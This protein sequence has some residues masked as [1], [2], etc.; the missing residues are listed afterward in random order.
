ME[1]NQ[2]P[3]HEIH[4][5]GERILNLLERI[6]TDQKVDHYELIISDDMSR[7]TDTLTG[8][9]YV[10][11]YNHL[12]PHDNKVTYT[13]ALLRWMIT[14]NIHRL[15]V[16]HPKTGKI[17]V[18]ERDVINF[19][20][21]MSITTYRVKLIPEQIIVRADEK[22]LHYWISNKMF[23][24]SKET[25]NYK[26]VM[27]KINLSDMTHDITSNYDILDTT[28]IKDAI[29]RHQP[30]F[31]DN[32]LLDVILYHDYLKN[33]ILGHMRR[34]MNEISNEICRENLRKMG[35]VDGDF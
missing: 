16:R 1:M 5:A 23:N 11:K 27:T 22:D 28:D 17:D 34:S 8:V 13:D 4:K 24:D 31:N 7:G 32:Y 20:P 10:F 3:L 25:A 15:F 9:A 12:M 6:C 35:D 29:I 26:W 2:T 30:V 18:I 33:V 14:T 19:V 21:P